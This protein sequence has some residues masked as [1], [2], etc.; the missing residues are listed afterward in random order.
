MTGWGS[1]CAQTTATNNN[2][3]TVT[4]GADYTLPISTP[5]KLEGTATDQDGDLMTFVWE[6]MDNEVAMMPP[7]ST[8]TGGP[9][10]RTF[11]PVEENFRYFPKIEHIINNTSDDWEVLPSVSR[12]M[13]FRMTVKD[14]HQGM[15]CTD[16]DDVVLTFSNN[17]GPFLVQSPNTN[18]QWLGGSSQSVTWDV[19]NT[20]TAPVSCANVD[21][22]LST[23]GGNTWTTTL[24]QQVP[25]TGSSNITVPNIDAS[26]CRV[27]VVCSDNIFFDMS[28]SNFSI[29]QTSNS[30]TA[31]ATAVMQV[32]CFGGSNGSINTTVQGGTPPFQYS[33]DGINFQSDDI[34]ANLSTGNYT[35]TVKDTNGN[36]SNTN[37]VTLTSPAQIVVNAMT[38]GNMVTVNTSGGT[39]TYFYSI[40]GVNFQSSNTFTDLVNG[41]Y[42][43]LVKD[44]NGCTEYETASIS[45]ILGAE[46]TTTTASCVGSADGIL[47]IT[48]VN[49]GIPPFL[50]SINGDNFQSSNQITGLVAGSYMVYV[51]DNSGT[52]TEVGTFMISDG[53]VL[54]VSGI[55]DATTI[56]ANG[57]GGTGTLMYSL[58]G[59]NFQPNNVFVGISNGVY[60]LSVMDENGCVAIDMV[61]VSSTSLKEI[62]FSLKFNLFP[63]PNDGHFMISLNQLTGKNIDMKIFDV[64]GKLIQ[65][66]DFEKTQDIFEQKIDVSHLSR[67]SYEVLI[68]D[69]EMSGH[70]RFIIVN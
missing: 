37:S 52:D 20:N 22:M 49:G 53:P 66:F 34:F 36:L 19:A 68:S 39:G 40:D 47:T 21:I 70:K 61:M 17:A 50:Y 11:D 27:M 28:N 64:A 13:K 30:I 57:Q 15:G 59:I 33:L 51:M 9:A 8:S 54:T 16:E 12:T 38:S 42:T 58:D 43:I 44:T 2:P 3:P 56:T 24:A 6:Q 10:F 67:G 69:G 45:T 63:N 60:T 65:E 26:T 31:A 46:V 55:A 35:I 29:M 7:V 14:N 32:S 5:F 23:D 25:N 4:S 41:Q 62:D 1:V 18:M 48:N